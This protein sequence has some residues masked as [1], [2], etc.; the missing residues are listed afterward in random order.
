[1]SDASAVQ[2]VLARVAQG[3]AVPVACASEGLAC[4][5]DVVVDAH[6]DG[7]PVCTVTLPWVVAGHAILFADASVTATVAQERLASL[8]SALAMPVCVVPRAA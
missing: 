2:R 7:K 6:Y 1:M 4:Q 8:A 5:Q 3:D